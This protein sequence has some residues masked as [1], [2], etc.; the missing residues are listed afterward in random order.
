MEYKKVDNENECQE[1]DGLLT[2]LISYESEY[3]R[4]INKNFTVSNFYKHSLANERVG[5]FVAKHN[6]KI[7]FIILQYT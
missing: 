3:D 6:D 2:S 1:C 4:L 7:T 5:I